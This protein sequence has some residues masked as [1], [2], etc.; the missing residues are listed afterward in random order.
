MLNPNFVHPLSETFQSTI[1]GEETEMINIW[2]CGSWI[3]AEVLSKNPN[4]VSFAAE[5]IGADRAA[6]LLSRCLDGDAAAQRGR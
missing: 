1:D 3:W 2:A 4:A 6:S 5:F